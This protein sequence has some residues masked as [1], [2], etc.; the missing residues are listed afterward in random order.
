MSVLSKSAHLESSVHM[1]KLPFGVIA[2]VNLHTIKK[3]EVDI[4][5]SPFSIV[6][7]SNAN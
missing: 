7:V 3:G 5:N 2:P 4:S 1:A 6:N